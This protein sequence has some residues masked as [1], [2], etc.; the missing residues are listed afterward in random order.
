[1]C[2]GK[3]AADSLRSRGCDTIGK[4]YA[5]YVH[6]PAA[7]SSSLSPP[8]QSSSANATR[9]RTK[10]L[11]RVVKDEDLALKI[12]SLLLRLLS[13]F[14]E[15]RVRKKKLDCSVKS[16][17]GHVPKC[18]MI[19]CLRGI[20]QRCG[21]GILFSGFIKTHAVSVSMLHTW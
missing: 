8:P 3:R 15:L 11:Q 17:S 14:E 20:C 13:A 1:M 21:T 18:A 7:A 19:Q 12:S 5:A 9:V 16:L 6:S 2:G 4:L 10:K